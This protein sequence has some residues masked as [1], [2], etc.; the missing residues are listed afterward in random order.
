MSI[1]IRNNCYLPISRV[2]VFI[3]RCGVKGMMVLLVLL[4]CIKLHVVRMCWEY[5]ML[6]IA[7]VEGDG[8]DIAGVHVPDI[9]GTGGGWG[10]KTF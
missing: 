1:I 4:S 8:H 6:Y 5:L 10:K 2:L 3:L 7:I 9:L